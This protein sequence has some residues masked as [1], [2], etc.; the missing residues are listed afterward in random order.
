M[1]AVGNPSSRPR[2]SPCWTAPSSLC[3]WPNIAAASCG[4]PSLSAV[5]IAVE[6]TCAPF[7]ARS[8]AMLTPNP[9]FSPKCKRSSAVP[10]RAL[11]KQKS[12][13]ITTCVKP[14]P[15]LITSR[16]NCSGVKA[17]RLSLNGSSYRYSTPSLVNL[18][19]RATGLIRRKAGV[20]GAKYARGCGSNVSTPSGAF[21]L[22]AAVR[23]MSI[24]D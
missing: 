3:Q 2:F 12:W 23:A 16:A 6:E 17:A 13:P 1:F 24:T 8:G 22:L 7:V 10:A 21:A 11:P 19:C 4:R 18:F 15:S 9:I 5:R 14:R 20:C